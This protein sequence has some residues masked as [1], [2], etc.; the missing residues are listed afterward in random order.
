[1]D[2]G[3]LRDQR[4]LIERERI[5]KETFNSILSHTD[6]LTASA[7][8]TIPVVP[9]QEVL[10]SQVTDC[11]NAQR[12]SVDPD[13]ELQFASI[14][15]RY[16]DPTGAARTKKLRINLVCMIMCVCVLENQIVHFN[17]VCLFPPQNHLWGTISENL[18]HGLQK[19][20]PN[21]RGLSIQFDG[22]NVDNASTPASD[23][24]ESDDLLDIKLK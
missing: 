15:A 7:V 13:G 1:V 21:I 19:E 4:R 11:S 2:H 8:S 18:L 17:S 5:R 3:L 20:Y 6:Q 22:S 16:L 12:C 23:G 24:V 10:P 9:V 14:K